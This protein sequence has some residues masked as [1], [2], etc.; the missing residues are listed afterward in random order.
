MK[1]IGKYQIKGLLGKGG[2]GRVYKAVLPEVEKI[3]AL[4]HLTPHEHMQQ[5][6]GKEQIDELFFYRS[7]G[8]GQY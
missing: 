7:P 5:L 8:A 3:V 1:T 4:K 6:L 2:M